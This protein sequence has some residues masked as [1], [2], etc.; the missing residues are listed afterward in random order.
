M[1]SIPSISG[2]AYG[3]AGV[4]ILFV[5]ACI[6]ACLCR[7]AKRGLPHAD[8]PAE[9]DHV[10]EA[11]LAAHRDRGEMGRILDAIAAA[12]RAAKGAA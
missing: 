6:V 12:N 10:V 7:A 11:V 3:A 1:N 8:P 2:I 4:M 5:A 9:P